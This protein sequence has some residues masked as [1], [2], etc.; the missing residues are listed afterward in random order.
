[1]VLLFWFS[2]CSIVVGILLVCIVE[3]VVILFI[4]IVMEIWSSREDYRWY[5]V[6]KRFGY[7]V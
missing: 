3:R 7:R 6:V 2:N 5:N 1:M 4:V